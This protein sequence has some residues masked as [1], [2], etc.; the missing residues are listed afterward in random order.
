M[1]IKGQ[2]CGKVSSL[3]VHREC[4]E[5]SPWL[6]V[7]AISLTP[8]ELRETLALT[9]GLSLN[10]QIGEYV[11]RFQQQLESTA[12]ECNIS[13]HYIFMHVSLRLHQPALLLI[14]GNFYKQHVKRLIFTS[15][16]TWSHVHS[17]HGCD[18]HQQV[19]RS[20]ILIVRVVSESQKEK[21]RKN[22][23][24]NSK[25]GKSWTVFNCE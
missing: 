4:W 7:F 9:T 12:T 11:L 22:Q 3:Q 2:G 17:H 13:I 15:S 18:K 10:L 21:K 6:L 14:L 1:T 19:S 23:Q 24:L 25:K 16:P 8:P 20:L 5:V